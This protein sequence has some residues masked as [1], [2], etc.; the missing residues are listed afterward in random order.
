MSNLQNSEDPMSIQRLYRFRHFP[1]IPG[2]AVGGIA[3]LPDIDGKIVLVLLV[4]DQ[5]KE[6]DRQA[7]F[8]ALDPA[9]IEVGRQIVAFEIPRGAQS[10]NAI[11]RLVPEPPL[12]LDDKLPRN[13]SRPHQDDTRPR[14]RTTPAE[15]DEI[16]LVFEG[17]R[18]IGYF[19]ADHPEN[20]GRA[21]DAS[22]SASDTTA[23][24]PKKNAHAAG[25]RVLR[26]RPRTEPGRDSQADPSQA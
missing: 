21:R 14:W 23:P 3:R 7:I 13:A 17:L 1:P 6:P 2:L 19:N 24:D 26:F 25:A 5:S 10:R 22:G 16:D 4:V 11:C 12:P 15:P 18:L 8:E 9:W 20:G